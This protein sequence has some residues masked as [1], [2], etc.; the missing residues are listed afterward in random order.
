MTNIQSF[1]IQHS[2]FFSLFVWPVLTA[3]LSYLLR[4]ISNNPKTK[5]IADIIASLGF[6]SAKLVESIK[7]MVIKTTV[8]E[9]EKKDT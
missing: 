8:A 2:L 5:I 4:A 1:V 7:S 6:D 9:V 3:F